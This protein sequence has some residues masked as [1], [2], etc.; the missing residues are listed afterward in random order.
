MS[1]KLT[2]VK[3]RLF[4]TPIIFIH[5]VCS[6]VFL[7][8][9]LEL[10][11]Q[12]DLIFDYLGIDPIVSSSTCKSIYLAHQNAN[13]PSLLTV[14]TRHIESRPLRDSKMKLTS[15]GGGSVNS[16]GK[17]AVVIEVMRLRKRNGE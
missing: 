8:K 5:T 12:A 7:F 3:V 4:L 9:M 14:Y 13:S 6:L 10:R 11:K 2:L 15:A 17:L 1:A 16:S